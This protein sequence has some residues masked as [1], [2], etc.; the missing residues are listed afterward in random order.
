MKKPHLKLVDNEPVQVA[1]PKSAAVLKAQEKHGK[2]FAHESGASFVWR[3]GPSV[4]D[5]WLDQRK[6]ER[7]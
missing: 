1:A 5:A 7:K 3:S 2:L 6:R 4:L